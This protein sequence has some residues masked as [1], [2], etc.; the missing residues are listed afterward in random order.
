MKT[1]DWC[2]DNSDLNRCFSKKIRT[3]WNKGLTKETDPRIADLSKTL[4][5]AHLGKQ[6][7]EQNGMFRK[8]ITKK[9]ISKTVKEIIKEY[10][11]GISRTQLN[12][13]L[14]SRLNC[15]WCCIAREYNNMDSML[16]RLGIHLTGGNVALCR[17]NKSQNINPISK[18][19][20]LSVFKDIISEYNGDIGREKLSKLVQTKLGRGW[21]FI[22][23]RCGTIDSILDEL[24]VDIPRGLGISKALK[25]RKFSTKWKQNISK[26]KI[27]KTPWLGLKHTEETKKILSE[28]MKGENNHFYGKH[29]TKES[30][31]QISKKNKGIKKSKEFIEK[32][33][34]IL[35]KAWT[36]PE[37]IK[38]MKVAFGIKPNKLEKQLISLITL[39][40]LPYRY[41]GDFRFWIEGRNPDFVNY[42][43]EKKII[44]LFGNYW[45]NPLVNP[46]V[47]LDKTYDKTIEHY[48]KYGFDCL[49][50]W[51]YELS[52]PERIIEKINQFTNNE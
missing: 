41:T 8:D 35:K 27:G 1:N 16:Y 31:E 4:S 10:G 6:T 40:K 9:K 24:N 12:K 44:E 20:I 30:K 17:T 38:K 36:N 26:S 50:L 3:V 13:L 21:T 51:D 47:R 33:R 7:R 15:D 49:I 42:N 11:L 2:S 22:N 52:N 28:S 39:H 43:G 32:R 14:T 46:K 23:N 5:I 34:V 45:H 18:E 19:H 48:K 29:H 25:G 37:Y